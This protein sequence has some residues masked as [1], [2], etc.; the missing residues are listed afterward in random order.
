MI[1]DFSALAVVMP[2]HMLKKL[3]V[4]IIAAMAFLIWAIARDPGQC[5]YNCVT[6]LSAKRR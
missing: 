6:D 3:I 5:K 2:D 1:A 4:T